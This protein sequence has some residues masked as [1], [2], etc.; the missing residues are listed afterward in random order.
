[1]P[2]RPVVATASTRPRSRASS[3]TRPTRGP[4]ALGRCGVQAPIPASPRRPKSWTAVDWPRRT[5][6]PWASVASRPRA[7]RRVAPSRRISPGSGERLDP[8]GGRDGLAG[9]AQVAVTAGSG[10]AGHDLAGGDADADLE[11]LAA[12]AD[13]LEAGTDGQ[14]REAGPE[15]VVVVRA[16]PAEDGED[17]VADELL[18]RPVE[19]VDRVGHRG[20]RRGH[21]GTDLLRIVLGEHPDVVD[22]IGE[23]G[24]DDAPVA[25]DGLRSGEHA[26]LPGADSA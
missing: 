6:D 26:Q 25:T 22:E 10:R 7:A 14:G 3:A 9:Q 20:E 16:R 18:A 5:T 24:G 23:E 1:M 12:I 2:P 13:L 15:R 21:A 17:R 8:R 11:R 19:A 4:A